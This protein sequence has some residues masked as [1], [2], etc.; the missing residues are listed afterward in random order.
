M[1][2]FIPNLNSGQ[3]LKYRRGDKKV[4]SDISFDLESLTHILYYSE[5]YLGFVIPTNMKINIK[6]YFQTNSLFILVKKIKMSFSHWSFP[7]LEWT[8]S[9]R[10]ESRKSLLSTAYTYAYFIRWF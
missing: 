3:Q 8:H 6:I 9:L 1:S 4:N 2:Q 7:S 5:T 10:W